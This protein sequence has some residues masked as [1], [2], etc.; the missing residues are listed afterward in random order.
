MFLPVNVVRRFTKIRHNAR[1]TILVVSDCRGHT[2]QVGVNNPR[3]HFIEF[4]S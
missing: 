1:L 4:L 2:P 3:R